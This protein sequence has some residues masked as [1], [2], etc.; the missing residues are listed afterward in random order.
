MSKRDGACYEARFVAD[1]LANGL[2]ISRPEGDFLPYDLIVTKDGTTFFRV[3]IKG[4]NYLQ[5]KKSE[6]YK[7]QACSGF[8]KKF[9][10]DPKK[11]DVLAAYVAPAGAW[12]HVPIGNVK[13]PSM[14]LSPTRPSKGQYEVWKDAWNVY[15]AK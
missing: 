3:Q 8:K 13:A 7:V 9:A 10:L 6:T 2:D 11:V 1:A 5:P 15:H 14:Y 12:Y 4:T